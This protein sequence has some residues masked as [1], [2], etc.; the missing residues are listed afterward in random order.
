MTADYE[1]LAAFALDNLGGGR[2]SYNDLSTTTSAINSITGQFERHG[3]DVVSVDS[4]GSKS[5][6]FAVSSPSGNL[7]LSMNGAKVFRHPMHTEQICQRKHLTKR[8]LDFA[9]LPTP[10]GAD[11]TSKDFPSAQAFFEMLD[12]PVVVKPTNAGGSQ[13]VTVGVSSLSEFRNAW[14]KALADGRS[15]SNV[16]VEEF[17]K[18]IEIRAFVVGSEAVSIV[19]RVQPFVI[20]DGSASLRVLIDRYANYREVHY[21]SVQLPFVVD[22]AFLKTSGYGPDSVVASDVV[23]FLNPLAL[24]TN[25]ALL[26]DVTKMVSRG[27]HDLA[28]KAM[29]A[30]PDLEVAGVDILVEDLRNVDSA[31]ILE[32]NTAPSMNLH[33]YVTHGKPRSVDV[34][35]VGYFRRVD[36]ALAARG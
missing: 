22:W 26:V 35:V 8:M 17:V 25:G 18:G 21:R 20:G 10:A 31:V 24:P 28:V 4:R 19:A 33:R 15:D 7:T 2:I 14:S 32:V 5:P 3:W 11:F 12:K 29:S 36:E 1:S 13:G 16:L 34:D 27:I 30:I 9:N 6:R 23:V